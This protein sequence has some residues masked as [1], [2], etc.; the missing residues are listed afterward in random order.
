MADDDMQR[1]MIASGLEP[2]RDST[3]DQTRRFVAAEIARWAPIIKG[4]GL[5]LD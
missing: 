1:M 5:K 3:P 4:I 2:Q